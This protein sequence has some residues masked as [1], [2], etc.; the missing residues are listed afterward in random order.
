MAK[1]GRRDEFEAGVRRSQKRGGTVA[2]FGH[3]GRSP[4]SAGTVRRDHEGR[5]DTGARAVD[6]LREYARVAVLEARVREEKRTA[7]DTGERRGQSISAP[8]Q[9]MRSGWCRFLPW[10]P[11]GPLDRCARIFGLS[12]RPSDQDDTVAGREREPALHAGSGEGDERA[13]RGLVIAKRSY[14]NLIALPKCRGEPL[15]VAKRSDAQRLDGSRADGP[16]LVDF[17]ASAFRPDE[18]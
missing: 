15:S 8:W 11:S 1:D 2:I 16:E 4:A 10:D 13:A 9:Y 14:A 17:A 12:T 6:R 3:R 18:M 5:T 7:P